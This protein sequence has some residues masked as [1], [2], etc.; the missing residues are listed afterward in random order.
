MQWSTAFLIAIAFLHLST[1]L[2]DKCTSEVSSSYYYDYTKVQEERVYW[3]Y[4]KK[5]RTVAIGCVLD[6]GENL[7][8]G[9][10]Y[11]TPF[12]VLLCEK[13]NDTAVLL[14]P[15]KCLMN[16]E[17]MEKGSSVIT[18]SFVYSCLEKEGRIGLVITG[19]VGDN[20]VLA[21]I[22][23][24]FTRRTFLF[25]CLSEG[26]RV[27]HK[28]IGCIIGGQRVGI[29]Q[30]IN[31]G[32]FWYK[33]S[34]Y[35]NGGVKVIIM[36]CVTSSGK[37]ID[38]GEK[39]RDRDGGF[40]F[41]CKQKDLGVRIV[42]AG[43]IAK[44]FGVLKEFNFGESWYTRPVGSLSYRVVC[45]GNEETVTAEVIECIANMDQGRKV[46][47]VGECVK[48]GSDRMFSCM[49][50]TEGNVL[51]RLTFIE[52]HSFSFKTFTTIEGDRCPLPPK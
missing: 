38:A 18:K 12:F 35:G 48:Y 20:K 22:G 9:E 15:I 30:V 29:H 11:R 10:T 17:E 7:A 50:Q 13:I 46:I 33:C 5:E 42:F 52:E 26:Y 28:A 25:T 19:C 23:E 8:F 31:I 37:R 4:I 44:E 43:C 36:G 51:A 3:K 1:I 6:S 27:I 32:K 47:K 39:Y 21:K 24:S 2:C 16:G 34:R 45:A 14:R 41:H 49:K 40:L